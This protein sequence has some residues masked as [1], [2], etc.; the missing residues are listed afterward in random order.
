MSHNRIVYF[1]LLVAAGCAGDSPT[2]VIATGVAPATCAGFGLWE[3]SSYVL[4]YPVGAVY[5][6]NQGNCSGFGHSG[7]WAFGYDFE[8]PIGSIVSAARE[9]IVVHAQ[10]GALDGDSNRTNLITIE[11]SD[12]TVA[13]YSHLTLNGV[14]V[15]IG[16]TVQAGD[17]I[18]LS[19]NTGNTGGLPHLH[20][21]VHPCSALPGLP[22]TGDCPSQ[23]ANFR[24]TTANP[25]GPVAGGTY[26]A[27]ATALLTGAGSLARQTQG[28]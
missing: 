2:G 17:V 12:G 27:L 8:M 19:G 28:R 14:H 25:N 22:G 10:D 5:R 21:S 23:A 13:L 24:N 20:F 26:E 9:G 15:T 1:L 3:T 6:L 11:H 4:P 7:F 18:G 16:Q